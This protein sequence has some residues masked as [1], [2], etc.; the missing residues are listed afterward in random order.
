MPQKRNNRTAFA[1]IGTVIDKVLRQYRPPT[2]QAMLKV[3]E[4]WTEAVGPVIAANAKPVA[5]KGDMLLVHVCSSTWLH[6]LRFLEQEMILKLNG[7]LGGERVRRI[8]LK[9]GTI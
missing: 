4:V 1:P 6:H 7:L 9:I 8:K 5:F 2:D 3:W